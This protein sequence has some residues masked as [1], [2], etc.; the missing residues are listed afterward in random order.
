MSAPTPANLQQAVVKMTKFLRY[1]ELTL[2]PLH[3][4][5]NF[6]LDQEARDKT[7]QQFWRR[8]II[9]GLLAYIDSLLWHLKQGMPIIA[10]ISNAQLTSADLEIIREQRSVNIKGKIEVRAN[11][12]KFRDNLKATFSLFGKVC[13]L[14]FKVNCDKDFDALCNTYDLRS[15]LMHPK[16]PFD[17]NVSDSD[18]AA[19]KQGVKWL[20]Q[21]YGRLMTACEKAMLQITKSK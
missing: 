19:S 15:R 4:D 9:R 5:T 6:A 2:A 20:Q 21:D 11:R 12:L 18:V 10:S 17:L 3:A 16:K 14:D 13:G 1:M 7:N 8:T